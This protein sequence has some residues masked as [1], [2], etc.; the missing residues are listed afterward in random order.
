V[1]RLTTEIADEDIRNIRLGKGRVRLYNNHQ[2][3][4]GTI[5]A[6]A[7]KDG[8]KSPSNDCPLREIGL[9]STIRKI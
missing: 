3:V 7:P 6:Q 5:S 2:I 1:A 9:L 8:G 4:A